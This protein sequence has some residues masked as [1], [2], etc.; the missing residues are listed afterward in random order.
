MKYK[1]ART[2]L[3]RLGIDISPFPNGNL[4]RKIELLN[5]FNIDLILDVG[6]SD[7]GFVQQIR[8]IGYKGKILSFEPISHTYQQ[9]RN[10]AQ[11]DEHWETL[12]IALGDIDG[13][14]EINISQNNDSSSFLEMNESHLLANPS[15]HFISKETVIIRKLDTIFPDYVVPADNVFLKMDV[16]G[17]EN[18]VLQGAKES[19]DKIKGIQIEMSFEE[20]YKSS[21]LF[22]EMKKLIESQ[23]FTLC[24]LE[25]GN[26]SPLSG[27]L[28]QADGIFFRV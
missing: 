18:K 19:L 12:N 27:K 13:E 14:N 23:G 4:L 3:R 9:L 7:G 24:L 20:L 10:K 17:Y 11:S 25:S 1:K 2:F 21:L 22:D 16:Q 8:S 28:L 15:S 26:R 5:L 6:A